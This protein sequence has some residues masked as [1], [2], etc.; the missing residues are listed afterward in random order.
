M[1]ES[2]CSLIIISR[3]VSVMRSPNSSHGRYGDM[4]MRVWFGMRALK[5]KLDQEAIA[6][7]HQCL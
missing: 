2:T 6:K 4:N 5:E 7:M 3:W 1:P